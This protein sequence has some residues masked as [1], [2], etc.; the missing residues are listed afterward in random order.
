MSL[1]FL[2]SEDKQNGSGISDHNPNTPSR[3]SNY[4]TQSVRLPPNSQVSYVSSQ[5]VLGQAIDLDLQKS[6]VTTAQ[7]GTEAMN[8]PIQMV[9]SSRGIYT[10]STNAI[11]NDQALS[12][13]EFGMDADYTGLT[14][15]TVLVN[16]ELQRQSDFGIVQLYDPVSDKSELQVKVRKSIDQYNLCFNSVGS[17][18]ELL[19]G[20][21]S[22]GAGANV[23]AGLNF[24]NKVDSIFQSDIE[25]IEISTKAGTRPTSCFGFETGLVT[26]LTNATTRIQQAAINYYNTGFLAQG[27]EQNPSYDWGAEAGTVPLPSFDDDDYS[28]FFSTGEIKKQVGKF[29]PSVAVQQSNGGGHVSP[30]G[31]EI[32]SGGYGIQGFSN[33]D[34]TLASAHYSAGVTDRV[35]YC[36]IAPF[37]AGVQSIPLV[38]Q[39]GYEIAKFA[40]LP[41]ASARSFDIQTQYFNFVHTLNKSQDPAI[42]IG[43]MAHYLFG[44]KGQDVLVGGFQN[45]QIS[46]EILKASLLNND[47]TSFKNAEFEQ[48]G[49]TLDVYKLSKGINTATADGVEYTF[50]A[51]ANY[52]INV[53]GSFIPRVNAALFFRY[54]WVNKN[55]MVIEFTLSVDAYS[56]TYDTATDEPY[57]PPGFIASSPTVPTTPVQ[58]ITLDATTTGGSTNIT[59]GTNFVDS[60]GGGGD[61]DPNESYDHIF[62]APL[63]LNASFT[64]TSPMEFEHSTFAMYDRMGVQSSPDGVTW[65]NVSFAGFRSSANTVAPWSTSFGS[66]RNPGWIFPKDLAQLSSL[67]GNP[68]QTFDVGER[69]V[70]FTFESDGSAQELGWDLAMNAVDP[71]TTPNA[72]DPRDKWCTLSTMNMNDGSTNHSH[73]IPSYMGDIGMVYYAVAGEEG[74]DDQGS[75]RSLQKGWLDVRQTNRYFRDNNNGG[76]LQYAPFANDNPAFFE[77]GLGTLRVDNDLPEDP[78]AT[79]SN[80]IEGKFTNP[81]IF[82]SDAG[83]EGTFDLKNMSYLGVP[84]LTTDG[85]FLNMKGF[86]MFTIRNPKTEVGFVL[87]YNDIGESDQVKNVAQDAVLKTLQ[88]SL[89]GA[90][91]V[92]PSSRNS[93]NHIQLTNLPIASQNGVVSS[94]SK[95]IYVANTLCVTKTQDEGSYRFFCDRTTFPIWIDLNNLEHIELNKIDVLITTDDNIE[96]RNLKGTTELVLMFRQKENGILPNSIPVNSMSMTRTY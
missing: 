58:T 26:D 85:E 25:Y 4:L 45:F 83:I 31:F 82:S 17:N 10:K 77:S 48:I 37:F 88:Y 52:S 9:N 62:V 91:T 30:G 2:K 5:Y 28:M 79:S 38:Q 14:Y 11:I 46:C 80:L 92:Q 54:R 71:S 44:M 12:A 16:G 75:L 78:D 23:P 65:T 87:G 67:G 33:T 93:T 40:G 20:S 70:R 90:N 42:R 18:P 95:T 86:P 68:S 51:G 60:G 36:G 94:I 73:F 1:V 19:G 34:N 89:D 13:N 47:S 55:Q 3:F 15:K 84:L 74:V 96:Q 56:G 66:P 6:F 69:Y 53:Y 27:I 21:W 7:K 22:L 63:G 32:T 57:E 64:I 59:S 24:T 81:N 8:M 50:D 29:T 49:R 39:V 61:Y 35:G 72:D 43:A 76:E 41:E